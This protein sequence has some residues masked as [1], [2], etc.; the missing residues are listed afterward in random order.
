MDCIF[1]FTLSIANKNI[2]LKTVCGDGAAATPFQYV[3][4]EKRK[5]NTASI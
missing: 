1:V 3:R 4:K 2:A 5:K